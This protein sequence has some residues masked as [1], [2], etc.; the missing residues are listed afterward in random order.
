M[1]AK[2]VIDVLVEVPSYDDAR[3]VLIPALNDESWEYWW[4]TDHMIFIKRDMVTGKRT[5]H[6]HI[7]PPGH[8][9]WEGLAFRDYL[10]AHPETAGEY[11]ALKQELA[12]LFRTERE[13]YTDAKTAF[14]RAITD[15]ARGIQ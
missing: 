12:A 3:R 10:I 11:A 4:Y 8:R 6:I 15:K 9:L 14:I 5:H 2:P 13:K 1:P 7:A